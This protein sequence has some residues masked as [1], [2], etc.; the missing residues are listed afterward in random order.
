MFAFGLLACAVGDWSEQQLVRH[1]YGP[2]PPCRLVLPG[3]LPHEDQ[4]GVPIG[5]WCIDERRGM[6]DSLQFL[7]DQK[8][9]VA[10]FDNG[11][12]VVDITD[13]T[14]AEWPHT[15]GVRTTS[16]L[17]DGSVVVGYQQGVVEIRN[18]ADGTLRA[19]G[20]G[21]GSVRILVEHE[22]DLVALARDGV[23]TRARLPDLRRASSPRRELVVW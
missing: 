2:P 11:I 22:G 4:M 16:L 20:A 10:S 3:D 23:R 7:D 19:S 8:L 13:G 5:A 18:P 17:S 9:L 1:K 14:F 12:A 6:T 21:F 15:R